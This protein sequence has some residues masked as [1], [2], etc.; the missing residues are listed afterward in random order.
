MYGA[1]IEHANNVHII[2][3]T[4]NKLFV[5]LYKIQFKNYLQQSS[6]SLTD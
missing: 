1:S 4:L 5:E 2:K 3:L 6:S